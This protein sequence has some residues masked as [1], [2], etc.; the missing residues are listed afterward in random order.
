MA[1]RVAGVVPCIIA[2]LSGT[3][4]G[5]MSSNKDHQPRTSDALFSASTPAAID[6]VSRACLACH[7]G[8]TAQDVA[9]VAPGPSSAV[10]GH[11]RVSHPVGMYY[12]DSLRRDPTGYRPVALL[13]AGTRLVNGRVSCASCHELGAHA[14]NDNRVETGNDCMIRIQDSP[15]PQAAGRCTACHV[16]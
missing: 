14:E 16:M 11:T 7:D 8:G 13:N 5:G 2:V 12:D 10:V 15:G 6:S 4:F 3:C 9:I 1:K